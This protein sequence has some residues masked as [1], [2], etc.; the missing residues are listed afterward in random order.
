MPMPQVRLATDMA[1]RKV[2][3]P[4]RLDK[5]F[6]YNPMVTALMFAPAPEMIAGLGMPSMPPERMMAALF[7][8]DMEEVT[9]FYEL[10]YRI[11]LSRRQARTMLGPQRRY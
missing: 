7:G 8:W 1:G 11:G 3:V 5:V 6:G 9:R 4:A 10:F 2:T